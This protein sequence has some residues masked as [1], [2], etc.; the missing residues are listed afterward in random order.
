MRARRTFGFVLPLSP[1]SRSKTA[2]GLF[3]VG[4][5]VLALLHEM[6]LVYAHAKPVSQ[7]PAISLDSMASSSD[8]NCVSLRIFCARIWS[9]EMPASSQDSL[10]GG[11]MFVRKRVLAIAWAPP[12]LPGVGM[13]LSPL[14]TSRSSRN[15]DSGFIVG[16]NPNA[17]PSTDGVQYGM[18]MAFGTYTTPKRLIGLAAVFVTAVS[19]GTIPSSNGNATVAPMPRSIVRRDMA[20]FVII[21]SPAS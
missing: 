13:Q 21:I 6:V 2:R 1:K 3:C 14:S 8:A 19:A 17:D 10:V 12:G 5:G 18:T 15:A 9:M 20:F 4:N 7:A 16:M 11:E